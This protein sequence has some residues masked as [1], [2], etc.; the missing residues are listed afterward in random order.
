MLLYPLII[1]NHRRIRL[2]TNFDPNVR[3]LA[4]I[5]HNMATTVLVGAGIFPWLLSAFEF[6]LMTG[7]PFGALELELWRHFDLGVLFVVLVFL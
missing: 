3:F 4:F 7:P 5:A 1:L 2:N 6:A